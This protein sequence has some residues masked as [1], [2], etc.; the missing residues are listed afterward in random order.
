MKKVITAIGNPYYNIELNKEK[1][2]EVI[3]RDIQYKEAI[4]EILEKNNNINYIIISEK[5]LGNI[6]MERL[7]KK[8]KLNNKKIEIIVLL[9]NKNDKKE[10]FFKE[11]GINKIYHFKPGYKYDIF[12]SY[13]DYCASCFFS[14]V[15]ADEPI[16]F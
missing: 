5:I 1:D 4:L 7:I 16:P 11:L 14:Y 9:F 12:N 13:K 3:G 2:I 8:I 15:E 6:S 10:K